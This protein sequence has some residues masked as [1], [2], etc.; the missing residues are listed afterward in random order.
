MTYHKSKINSFHT[1]KSL[2]KTQHKIS[3]TISERTINNSTIDINIPDPETYILDNCSSQ[4]SDTPPLQYIRSKKNS[5][6]NTVRS[7]SS[8]SLTVDNPNSKTF[9]IHIQID[10]KKYINKKHVE[11]KLQKTINVLSRTKFSTDTSTVNCELSHTLDAL[12]GQ[13]ALLNF[14]YNGKN[15]KTQKPKKYVRY[16][17]Y[18]YQQ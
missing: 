4:K 14:P 8:N 15:P 2:Q 3:N 16:Q 18:Q 11:N 1:I 10:P 9:T 13:P 17:Y 6:D 5:T 7:H 12:P